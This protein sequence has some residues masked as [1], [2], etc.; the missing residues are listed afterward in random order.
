MK[1]LPALGILMLASAAYQ[2]A[3]AATAP[4]SDFDVISVVQRSSSVKPLVMPIPAQ[5]PD[6]RTA[7]KGA[8]P[9][10]AGR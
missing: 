7:S 3:G 10:E 4:Y 2:T 1:F 6:K 5:E 8:G 9:S